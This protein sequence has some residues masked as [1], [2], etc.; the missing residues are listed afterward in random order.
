MQL[1]KVEQLAPGFRLLQLRQGYVAQ[2]LQDCAEHHQLLVFRDIV[3]VFCEGSQRDAVHKGGSIR[4]AQ[5][6]FKL[7]R[8][9]IPAAA[10]SNADGTGGAQRR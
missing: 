6:V 2:K 7:N 9:F 5:R 4:K 3:A 10:V 1:C 8:D